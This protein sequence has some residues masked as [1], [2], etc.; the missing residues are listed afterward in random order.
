ML[1]ISLDKVDH[2]IIDHLVRNAR[3]PSKT[4]TDALNKK[5]ITISDRAVRKRIARLEKS[6]AIKGYHAQLDF[7]TVGLPISRVMLIK[8]KP[9]E[10]YRERA[11]DFVKAVSKSKFVT[12]V[13]YVLG[14]YNLICMAHYA[15]REQATDENVAFQHNFH[16]IIREYL[17]YDCQTIK[18]SQ[19]GH[20][21]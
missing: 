15:S 10:N 5:G 19:V 6:G 21:Y 12:H 7:D 4:I 3:T 8:F 2:E 11:Q 16:D 13:A 14:E 18:Q 20:A 1:R 9:V 17:V